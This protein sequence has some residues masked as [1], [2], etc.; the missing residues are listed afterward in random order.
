MYHTVGEWYELL[1]AL[2]FSQLRTAGIRFD[3]QQLKLFLWR[4]LPSTITDTF[5]LDSFQVQE[6]R[7]NGDRMML[8]VEIDVHEKLFSVQVY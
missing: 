4:K 1:I 7:F 3:E 8:G 5:E 6:S 2:E